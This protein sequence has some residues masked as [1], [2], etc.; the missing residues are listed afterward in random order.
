MTTSDYNHMTPDRGGRSAAQRLWRF[1]PSRQCEFSFRYKSLFVPPQE[2][3]P[4]NDGGHSDYAHNN[5]DPVTY[6]MDQICKQKG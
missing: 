6:L 5:S 3:D 1:Q 2:V 4:H